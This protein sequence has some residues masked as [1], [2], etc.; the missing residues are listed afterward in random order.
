MSVWFLKK[1]KIVF[2]SIYREVRKFVAFLRVETKCYNIET[3]S[4]FVQIIV[5]QLE[6]MRFSS[7]IVQ[8]YAISLIVRHFFP[9]NIGSHFL[10]KFISLLPLRQCTW[11]AHKYIVHHMDYLCCISHGKP[12]LVQN[13][14]NPHL[15]PLSRTFYSVNTVI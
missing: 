9:D 12:L 6:Y 14:T 11:I 15:M 3:A 5:L 4:K 8:F 7:P 13:L 10:L 2:L 1:Y